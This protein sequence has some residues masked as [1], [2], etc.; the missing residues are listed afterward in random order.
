MMVCLQEGFQ[1]ENVVVLSKRFFTATLLLPITF[2]HHLKLVV[3]SV[4]YDSYD[5][6]DYD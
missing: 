5:S 2:T 6:Y 3:H 4:C 1:L